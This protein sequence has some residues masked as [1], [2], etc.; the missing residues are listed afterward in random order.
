[1]GQDLTS[2]TPVQDLHGRLAADFPIEALLQ[3][4]AVLTNI[5]SLLHAA[6]KDSTLPL[7]A[8][9]LLQTLAQQA[10][11]ALHLAQ[12]PRFATPALPGLGSS[13]TLANGGVVRYMKPLTSMH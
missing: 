3:C 1:M 6:D 13:D 11:R 2:I 12:D 10:K 9:S 4:P 8:V 5:L 7:A